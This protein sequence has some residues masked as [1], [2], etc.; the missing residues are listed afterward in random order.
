ME[1]DRKVQKIRIMCLAALA[2]GAFAIPVA[3]DD[4]KTETLLPDIRLQGYVGDR[5]RSMIAGH[6]ERT[7]VDY[8]T[9]PFQEKT[10]RSGRWQTEFWGKFMHAAVPFA[11]AGSMVLDD[12][13]RRGTAAILASQEPCGYI[14]NYPDDE[15]LGESWDVWG[16]KYTLMGLLH[17]C[18]YIGVG[19]EAGRKALT[20]ACRLCDYVIREIGPNGRRGREL[21]TT[22]CWSGFASSSILEPIVWLYRRTS[23]RKYLDFATSIVKGMTEPASGPRLLDLALEGKSVADRNGYGNTPEMHGGYVAKHNRWKAYEMMSC[24]QG[25]LEYY[26]VTGRKDLF[27]AALATANQIV[28]DEVNL[29]GGCS[30]SEA[31]FHG[32]RK[33]HLPYTRLQETCVTTTWMR[34]CEKLLKMTDDPKW[35][36]QLER[37]FYNAYLASLKADGSAFASY[38]PLSGCR[39][40]GQDHCYMH[41][42]C[43]NSNG[44]R[45][46]LC[47]LRAFYVQTEK[48]S[49][50]NFYASANVREFEM[51]TRYPRDGFVRIL[52]HTEGRRD[53]RLRIPNAVGAG[54]RIALNGK[55]LSGVKPGEYFVLSHNWQFGD[56]VTLEFELPVISHTLAGSDGKQDR[57]HYVAFTRGPILLAR[58]SRFGDGNMN[59]PFHILS[60]VDGRVQPAFRPVRTPSDD[61]WMAFSATLPIGSHSEN[62]EA[63]LDSTVTFCDYASAGNTWKRDDYYQTWFPV[64]LGPEE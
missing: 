41:V 52:S 25:L 13:V 51:Y 1:V 37:T 17:Y 49:T 2:A 11:A 38:T 9:A 44:P 40:R 6:L 15:R 57:P 58:D 46:F 43:C 5:L 50:F 56:V 48:C 20:A 32:A 21:W 29:A 36:D 19:S 54:S 27:D 62:P 47:F 18:D 42:N 35:A 34:L 61:V 3:A 33:Q 24:Y 39:Y 7:D 12:S 53:L 28:R 30:C 59:E 31:W 60:V 26:E 63:V 10:D 14:G 22:G 45:G 4:V 55:V 16:C 8:I 23:E 64:E